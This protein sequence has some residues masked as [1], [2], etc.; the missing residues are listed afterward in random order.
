[1]TICPVIT[2]IYGIEKKFVLS[3]V[4]WYEVYSKI[5]EMNLPLVKMIPPPLRERFKEDVSEF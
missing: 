3:V 2:D 1:M 5:D 4:A